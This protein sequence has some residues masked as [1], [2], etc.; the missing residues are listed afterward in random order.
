MVETGKAANS[1]RRRSVVV[2]WCVVGL[3]LVAACAW[4]SSHGRPKSWNSH[5]IVATFDSLEDH[6]DEDRL[7]VVYVLHNRSGRDYRLSWKERDE[8]MTRLKDP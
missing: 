7:V 3:L 2:A 8:F 1:G 5:A 4:M 6:P